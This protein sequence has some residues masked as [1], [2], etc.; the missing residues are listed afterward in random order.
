MFPE[1]HLMKP[2]RL[3]GDRPRLRGL[4]LGSALGSEL[5]ASLCPSGHS[6]AQAPHL[7]YFMFLGC[8]DSGLRHEG[9]WE[10]N[11]LCFNRRPKPG[12]R[13]LSAAA[14]QPRG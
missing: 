5:G 4:V 10:F 8:H 12:R 9:G 1:H 3:P 11:C 14:E 2:R 13:R 7:F 6:P